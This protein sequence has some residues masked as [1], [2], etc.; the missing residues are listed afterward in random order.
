[1]TK[2]HWKVLCQGLGKAYFQQVSAQYNYFFN[3]CMKW[4]WCNIGHLP[5][6]SFLYHHLHCLF[7]FFMSASNV[8]FAV[9]LCW[10]KLCNGLHWSSGYQ[11]E[12]LPVGKTL[13]RICERP[14]AL[15]VFQLLLS[16]LCIYRVVK[17]SF[18]PPL[19]R[20]NNSL[21][22]VRPAQVQPVPCSYT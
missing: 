17:S 3:V 6:F 10:W 14:G 9:I 5:K 20:R 15:R 19:L 21:G 18:S 2:Y 13:T 22:F 12:K 8:S 16:C 7:I 1:M 11:S 4:Q